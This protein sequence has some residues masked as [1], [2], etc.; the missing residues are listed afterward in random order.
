MK[1]REFSRKIAWCGSN[2]EKMIDSLKI[3]YKRL[4]ATLA[5]S[6]LLV[7]S[8][9]FCSND[10]SLKSEIVCAS[11][12]N[13]RITVKVEITLS[14]E[15]LALYNGE[16]LYLLSLES[17]SV[18]DG[19]YV[20]GEAKAKSKMVFNI[21]L[22]EQ[23]ESFLSSALAL[24]RASTDGAL[25]YTLLTE[26]E[27][28]SNSS[29]LAAKNYPPVNT[30]EIKGLESHSALDCLSVG[31]TRALVEVEIN[32]VLL[33]AYKENSINYI[34]DGQSYYFDGDKVAELDKKIKDATAADL[35]VYLRT[36]ISSPDK[37][38]DHVSELY[39][40]TPSSSAGGFAINAD[41]SAAMGYLRA[42]Y[43]FLADRYNSEDAL[44]IDLII[45]EKVNDYRKNCASGSEEDFKAA[46]FAWVRVAYNIFQSRNK[47]S[48]VYVSVDNNMRVEDTQ[49]LGAKV[50]LTQMASDAAASGQYGFSV[51]LSLGAGD[52]LGDI[53]SG[54][55]S[56]LSVVNANNFESFCDLIAGD[57][58][59]F[60]GKMRTVMIDSLALP[61][62]I[63]EQNRAAYYAYTYY[64][65]SEAGFDAFFYSASRENCDIFNQKGERRD[66]FFVLLMCGSDINSQLYD[67]LGKIKNSEI[68]KL[69][70]CVSTFVVLEQEI[71]CVISASVQS[72]RKDFPA[73]LCDFNRS[74][75]VYDVKASIKKDTSGIKN[76]LITVYSSL[77]D[78]TA[79]LTLGDLSAADVIESGY[80]GITM[81]T[82]IAAD[83]ELVITKN[84]GDI[85]ALYIGEAQ[86]GSVETTYY[87][88][89]SG[90]TDKIKASDELTVSLL[91]PD[92]AE[93]RRPTLTVFDIALYGSSGNGSSTVI[94]VI[95]VALSTLA[96]CGLLF[97]LTQRRRRKTTREKK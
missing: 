57:D 25:S 95:A 73:R 72:N 11:I 47:N 96:V 66:F 81:S 22:D 54:R 6:V 30:N 10:E 15:D 5:V 87:F 89:I 24:A 85:G 12:K 94:A 55:N 1:F 17:N 7:L 2:G 62:D 26:R 8:L 82:D 49:A 45:G 88:N 28:I 9:C 21:K 3:H 61:N 18:N 92:H 90:F 97:L 4:L 41:S 70:D 69:S 31:A 93:N 32:K 53:L 67:Y 19:A 65:A 42:F 50:F 77:E 56:D 84:G 74:G 68:P 63:S 29:I 37:A 86:V 80:I 75:S 36:V 33:P 60:G 51:A 13:D 59:L 91:M 38:E 44:A 39:Y 52:D 23:N 16:K 76:D 43:S 79:A 83:V 34:F 14:D 58:L 35:R 64:K 48:A 71:P 27:Y 40:G 20:V 78:G 46:Y